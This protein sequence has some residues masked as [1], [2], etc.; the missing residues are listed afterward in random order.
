MTL[1]LMAGSN[2]NFHDS[3]ILS[4]SKR[5]LLSHHFLLSRQGPFA[6]RIEMVQTKRQKAEARGKELEETLSTQIKD[7]EA[8]SS[9]RIDATY[10]GRIRRRYRRS[11]QGY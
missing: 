3:L 1:T 10:E 7:M 4:S 5:K 9:E 11:H 6:R 8:A 2:F